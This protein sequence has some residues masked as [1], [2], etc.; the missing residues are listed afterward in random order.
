[1]YTKAETLQTEGGDASKLVESFRGMSTPPK[2]LSALKYG[3]NMEEV[4][5]QKYVKIF[6]KEHQSAKHR[7]CGLFISEEDRFLGA[8][9]DL[10]LECS[11]CGKGVL[12]IKCPYS[13]VNEIPSPDNLPYLVSSDGSVTL[14]ENHAYFAQIQGQM[15]VIKRTWCYFFFTH[16]RD[17][18]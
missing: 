6:E 8:T 14:K 15:A 9:P 2:N 7:E 10:L 18:T 1:M 16:R 4:A 12:E 3:R 5:K 17:S 13:I 11:C